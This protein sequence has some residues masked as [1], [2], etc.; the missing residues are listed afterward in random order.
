MKPDFLIIPYEI[1]MDR[2][3]RPTDSDVYAVIYWFERM[4]D[5]KCKASN[6]VI[7]EVAC[8]EAR[9]V[10]ASLDRLERSGYIERV[11]ADKRHKIRLEIKTML[12]FTKATP[13][14]TIRDYP[15]VIMGSEKITA[16]MIEPGK[17]KIVDP[18]KE[19]PGQFAKRFFARDEEALKEITT[20]MLLKSHGRQ[21]ELLYREINKF[22]AYWTEPSKSGAKQRWEQQP[23]FEVRRR[24]AT[25]FNNLKERA[26]VKRSGAGVTI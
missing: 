22:I 20:E 17:V 8:I 1:K 24:L 9:S 25:W 13:A 3:L 21:E 19:T 26:M 18:Q 5:G 12:H 6:E 7:A 2:D 15:I 10:R 4:K 11:Y 14:K 23:T 16:G